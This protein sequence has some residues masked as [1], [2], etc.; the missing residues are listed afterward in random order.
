[1]LSLVQIILGLGYLPIVESSP[2]NPRSRGLG[3]LPCVE[4][5]PDNSRSRFS[6]LCGV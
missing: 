5:S 3:S 2:D 4:S 1:M 6:T